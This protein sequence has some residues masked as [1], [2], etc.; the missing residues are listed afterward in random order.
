MT[1][2]DVEDQVDDEEETDEGEVAP[3]AQDDDEASLEEI[4]AEKSKKRKETGDATEEDESVLSLEREDR[5]AGSLP[6]KVAPKQAT[7]FVC[8]RCF[9][10][11]HQSQLA[12]KKRGLCKDCA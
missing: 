9:L 2:E 4:L 1:L 5:V 7:E 11:K 8:R 3:A 12:N 10:V 6:G